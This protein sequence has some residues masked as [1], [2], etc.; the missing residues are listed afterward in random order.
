MIPQHSSVTNEHPTPAHVVE[1]SRLL[2][3]TIDLDPASS[4]EANM[5]VKATRYF[6]DEGDGLLCAWGGNVFLNPP[7]GK[8]EQDA[9]GNWKAM[10]RDEH[11]RQNGPGES[12]ML[13]WWESLVQRYLRKEVEQAI[14]IGFTLEILRTSQRGIPV[15]CFPRCYPKE[16]LRFGGKQP[17]HAN[18][19][20]W[21]PPSLVI[22]GGLSDFEH[23]KGAFSSI[24]FCEDGST[25]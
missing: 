5:V 14:F 9:E 15:Q 16:R 22:G 3:R 8:V 7:G 21:L 20:V 10:A 12:S 13:I 6:T 1:A 2:M 18:V 11:G 24:G 4:D 25:L 23:F 19:I 17:T